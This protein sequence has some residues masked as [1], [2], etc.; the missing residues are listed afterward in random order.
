MRQLLLI[1]GS[2]MLLVA[3][4]TEGGPS[5]DIRPIGDSPYATVLPQ[6]GGN[7]P[8]DEVFSEYAIKNPEA[9]FF[10]FFDDAA[11]SGTIRH[12]PDFYVIITD[13]SSPELA[14]ANVDET[15]QVM[16]F[17]LAE[18]EHIFSDANWPSNQIFTAAADRY[19]YNDNGDEI[20]SDEITLFI[21]V[22]QG[23]RTIEVGRYSKSD[24]TENSG[25]EY[26]ST[27]EWVRDDVIQLLG[28]MDAENLYQE[29]IESERD[30]ETGSYSYS[31]SA[32]A[33]LEQALVF[34]E[35]HAYAMHVLAWIYSTY[36]AY[37]SDDELQARALRYGLE[38]FNNFGEDI[39]KY[40]ILG[41]ALYA[42]GDLVAGD[43]YFD[44]AIEKSSSVEQRQYFRDSKN[45]VRGL[46]TI[47]R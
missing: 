26:F 2:L 8:E 27:L 29:A 34:D 43:W 17:D 7:V 36:P 11:I 31:E 22:Q 4:A 35:H 16:S 47:D 18:Y 9:G 46:H 33:L 39:Y 40:E 3:C 23:N 19:T 20:P 38:V 37:L 14:K 30:L 15:R 25:R 32:I 28:R 13:F 42:N 44:Q 5:H 41:A 21:V 12:C 1:L 10:S 24:I 6:C 45:T